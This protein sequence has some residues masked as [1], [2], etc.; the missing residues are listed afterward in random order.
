MKYLLLILMMSAP[1][2]EP[3]HPEVYPNNAIDADKWPG[4]CWWHNNCT[5][6]EWLTGKKQVDTTP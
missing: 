4:P 6:R 3:P 1:L 2:N 5:V